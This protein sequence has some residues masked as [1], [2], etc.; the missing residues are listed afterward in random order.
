MRPSRA[1]P[2]VASIVNEKGK[3]IGYKR[4]GCLQKHP[5]RSEGALQIPTLVVFVMIPH[6]AAGLGFFVQA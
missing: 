6:P 1:G 5:E 3:Q 4:I 2:S